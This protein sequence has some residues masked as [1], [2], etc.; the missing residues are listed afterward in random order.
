MNNYAIITDSSCDLPADL[1]AKLGVHVLP[2]AIELDEKTY[3]NYLDGRDISPQD[4]YRQIRAGKKAVT[5]A[6]SVGAYEDLMGQI[7]DEGKDILCLSF[8]SALSNT[9]SASEIA[10]KELAG[11]YPQRKI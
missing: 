9:C 7:L 11:Q 1:A 8:S 6:V 2:L 10:A 4:F 3:Q 5:S